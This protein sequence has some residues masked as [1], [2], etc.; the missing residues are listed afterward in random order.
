M[1]KNGKLTFASKRSPQL[2]GELFYYQ[3]NTYT[4]KWD[5]RFMYADAFVYFDI[6]D[7]QVNGFTM[8]PISPQTDFSF[9]FQDLNF[10]K[11]TKNGTKK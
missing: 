10:K 7:H 11:Q 4:V 8:K 9:D 3:D 1:N 2:T 6:Q 5:N